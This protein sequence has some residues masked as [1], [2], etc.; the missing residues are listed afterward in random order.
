MSQEIIEF[1][2]PISLLV[3]LLSG[4]FRGYRWAVGTLIL[5]NKDKSS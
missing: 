1:D 2:G 5:L 3:R 4:R